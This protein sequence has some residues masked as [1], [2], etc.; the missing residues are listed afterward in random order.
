MSRPG[1]ITLRRHCLPGAAF[2]DRDTAYDYA[3]QSMA[4]CQVSSTGLVTLSNVSLA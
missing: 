2:A 4:L 3:R 1:G